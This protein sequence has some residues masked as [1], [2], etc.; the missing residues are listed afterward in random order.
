MVISP[1]KTCLIAALVLICTLVPSDA[2]DALG[3]GRKGDIL[4]GSAAWEFFNVE[5]EMSEEGIE[6][7]PGKSNW[8]ERCANKCS[9]ACLG[10]R[11]PITD[12]WL[13]LLRWTPEEDCIYR[14][15][16]SCINADIQ[17]GGRQWKVRGRWPHRRVL[18]LREPLS[19]AFSVANLA[20]HAVGLGMILSVPPSGAFHGRTR[21]A[22]HA[23]VW[24]AA[25][26][27]S[28]LFHAMPTRL[29]ER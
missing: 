14:C 24:M 26:A 11:R 5:S 6:H 16:Q 7:V 9:N 25:W 28:A 20:A 21:L 2:L 13:T 18:G 27:S 10:M 22:V 19:V 23:C 15:S 17:R 3:I 8:A 4:D 12:R 1:R 29:T